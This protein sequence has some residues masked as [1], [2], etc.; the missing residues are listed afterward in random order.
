MNTDAGSP[1]SS[2]NLPAIALLHGTI[3][4]LNG[5]SSS[6]KVWAVV[7][8]MIAMIFA[9]GRVGGEV[10]LWA[11]LPAVMLAFMD[12]CLTSKAG[13]VVELARSLAGSDKLTNSAAVEII[14]MED[15]DRKAAGLFA[16]MTSPT[17]WPFYLCLTAIV[18]GLG[19]LLLLPTSKVPVPSPMFPQSLASGPSQGGLPGLRTSSSPNF[20]GSS[21]PRPMVSPNPTTPSQIQQ[22]SG[23]APRPPFQSKPNTSINFPGVQRG[24]S[25]DNPAKSLPPQSGPQFGPPQAPNPASSA[26]APPQ[27]PSTAATSP[28]P[29]G[30]APTTGSN[31]PPSL[32]NPSV[33]IGQPR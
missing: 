32:S 19:P 7:I 28:T 18:A 3:Q 15:G 12:A 33:P 6:C 23:P 27:K 26:V 8:S 30:A 29:S 25:S 5:Q 11:A 14:L 22:P 31:P 10:W 24:H 4:R 20:P 16:G 17:V 9:A 21:T 1:N 13:R 2:T